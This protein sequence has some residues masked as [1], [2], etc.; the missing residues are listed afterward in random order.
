MTAEAG[1]R[2]TPLD[3]RRDKSAAARTAADQAKAAVTELD[4]RLETNAGLTR[5]Q[6]QALRNAQAEVARL[7]RSL[8]NAAKER[9]RLT[10]QRAKAV[11][12]AAK[13]KTKAAAAET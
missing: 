1:E 9:K 10:K 11:A 12:K 8:K 3:T 2:P 6:S 5:E 7:E 4:H 13:A